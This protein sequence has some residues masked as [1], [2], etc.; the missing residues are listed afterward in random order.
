[1]KNIPCS[2]LI[3]TSLYC[4]PIFSQNRVNTIAASAGLT[5]SKSELLSISFETSIKG[6]NQ[7]G[8][9]ADRI[10]YSSMEKHPPFTSVESFIAGG[11][12]FKKQLSSTRNFKHSVYAGGA[13]GNNEGNAIY[14][15]FA[16]IEQ[17]FYS[18]ASAQLFINER[19][20]YI[21]NFESISWLPSLNIGIRLNL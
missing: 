7:L 17:T 20:I 19:L 13:V 1:M 10:F 9:I 21:L 2:L 6:I 5:F 8:L 16:G 12:Y 3:L 11:L 15:P 18:P 14:Y 4:Q